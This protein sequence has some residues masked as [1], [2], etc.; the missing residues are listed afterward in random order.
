MAFFL[1]RFV[2]RVHLGLSAQFLAMGLGCAVAWAIGLQWLIPK[3][4]VETLGAANVAAFAGLAAT[5][6]WLFSS[7]VT[8]RN[9]QRQNTITLLLNMRHSEIY[10]RHFNNMYFVSRSADMMANWKREVALDE[11]AK[12]RQDQ[13]EID[14]TLAPQ[15]AVS[16]RSAYQSV[17]YV[18]NYYEFIAVGVRSG[19]LDAH[20]VLRT[21][22]PHMRS[23]YEK[24]EPWIEAERELLKSRTY[25]ENLHWF[26]RKFPKRQRKPL[27][28]ASNVF[29]F[30]FAANKAAA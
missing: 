22:S 8:A 4:S 10:S 29:P 20:I 12:W 14:P 19:A 13:A 2:R 5:L 28:R 3:V 7:Y 15:A 1:V 16:I 17:I 21:V 30:P 11:T 27:V 6:G 25:F 26:S 24:F 9:A 23:Y 18:L